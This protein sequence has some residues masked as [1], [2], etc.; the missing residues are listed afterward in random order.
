MCGIAGIAR[1]DGASPDARILAR[2]NAALAHRGPDGEG[3]WASGAVALSHRR[4]A[5]IDPAGGAQPFVDDAPGLALTYNGE[6][7][8]F[9][10][11]RKELADARFVTDSDTEVVLRAYARWGMACL[12]KFRGMFAFALHDRRANRLYL[13]RDRLGIKPLYYHLDGDRVVFASELAAL[14]LCGDIDREVDES[15]LQGYLRFGYVATPATIW[16]G[17]RKLEP[18]CYLEIDL[19]S[20]KAAVHRYWELAPAVRERSADEAAEEL[21]ALLDDIIRLYVR[22]D[23]AF[24]AFLSGGVDSAVVSAL[25]AHVLDRPVRSFSIGFAEDSYSELP[26]AAEAARI[27]GAQHTAA[28]LSPELSESL[29]LGIAR[30]FGEP[31]ADSSALPTW[32]VSSLAAKDVKMVLSGD[33]GD[34]LFAGYNSYGAVLDAVSGKT[35]GTGALGRGLTWLGALAGVGRP[36]LDWRTVHHRQRDTFSPERCA[37]LL[38]HVAG[39]GGDE[40]AEPSAADPV[41]RC[42]FRDVSTYLLDDILTKVDRMSMDNSVEVR[43]PLLDHKLVEFAFGL[44]TELKIGYGADGLVETKRLLKRSASRF[45]PRAL[46]DRRKWGFGIPVHQWLNG[47]L[48]PMAHDLLDSRADRLSRYLDA[49]EVRDVV[50][51]YY[52]GRQEHVGE[53][54]NLLA[55]R[56]W[57]DGSGAPSAAQG[58]GIP[59]AAN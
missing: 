21:D 31:F 25:M 45:Y 36:R 24:G 23:V 22:S 55:L 9:V 51:A 35:G 1:F 19:S 40:L 29:L 58:A 50:R 39:S 47:P 30:R 13:V 46:V 18:G 48:K 16:R 3:I 54:W 5:I 2:I 57:L 8:N 52:A 38:G 34:E 7:Y 59:V 44:P 11:I 12:A 49:R 14:M 10:E 37:R 41:T 20:G 33:G 28:V 32:Y 6:V 15:G 43:V 17:V 4:L 42:Q 56:L 27:I 26:Y 53:L